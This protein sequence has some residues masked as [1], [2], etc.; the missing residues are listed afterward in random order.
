[1]NVYLKGDPSSTDCTELNFAIF[2][3]SQVKMAMEVQAERIHS[4]PPLPW[5]SLDLHIDLLLYWRGTEGIVLNKER[6]LMGHQKPKGIVP[7][8]QGWA[9]TKGKIGHM[10]KGK[11]IWLGM[12]SPNRGQLVCYQLAC[13]SKG[14]GL[15]SEQEQILITMTETTR[16]NHQPEPMNLLLTNQNVIDS[17]IPM[18]NL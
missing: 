14:Y 9:G 15:N 1:M 5:K 18:V 10:M 4:S 8:G 12:S 13:T 2:S 17:G 3:S 16:K 11:E 7:S 6:R